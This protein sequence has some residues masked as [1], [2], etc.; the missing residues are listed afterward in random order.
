MIIEP[1][2]NRGLMRR[3][4]LMLV[5]V[6]CSGAPKKEM[7]TS[8]GDEGDAGGASAAASLGEKWRQG[9]ETRTVE[10]LAP[11]YA[12]DTDLV[13]VAQGTA[14]RGWSDV[15]T[16]LS[17][18]LGALQAV[19]LRFDGAMTVGLGL[20]GGVLTTGLIRELD[21]GA[22]TVTERG[23][24]TLVVRKDS[25]GWVIVSEHYSYPPSID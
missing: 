25:L 8:L 2:Y 22:G 21:D 24:L 18:K 13:V 15:E 23:T 10:A 17:T 12:H 14:Y 6:G 9:W 20:D 7:N 5:L 19:H 11:L 1:R 16:F 4:I 3:L